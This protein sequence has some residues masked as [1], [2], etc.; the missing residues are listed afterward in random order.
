MSL[1]VLNKMS[2]K[3]PS[4]GSNSEW[5]KKALADPDLGEKDVDLLLYGPKSFAQA[6]RLNVLWIRYRGGS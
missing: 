2:R 3:T 6:L 5:K 4:R 1:V